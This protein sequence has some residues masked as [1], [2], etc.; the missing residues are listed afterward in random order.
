MSVE[1]ARALAELEG[2]DWRAWEQRFDGLLREHSW[3]F[4]AD[5]VIPAGPIRRL[6]YAHRVPKPVVEQ[7]IGMVQ[8]IG[9]KEGL[10][11][12]L[13]RKEFTD[14]RPGTPGGPSAELSE[15]MNKG[16]AFA[17]L[18]WLEEGQSRTAYTVFGFI[19]L[20]S[21]KATTTPA[22]DEWLQAAKMCPGAFSLVAYPEQLEYLR[23]VLGG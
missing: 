20:K 1:E 6:L 17:V 15:L 19:E 10:P 8:R 2:M 9:R 21:G 4:W 13:I 5:R 23:K 12:R 22:Q 3:D 18:P 16:Q 14:Y 11:D 7:L